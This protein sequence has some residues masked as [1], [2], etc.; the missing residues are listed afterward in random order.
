MK[1]VIANVDSRRVPGVESYTIIIQA[2]DEKLLAAGGIA[3]ERLKAFYGAGNSEH[4]VGIEALPQHV[5]DQLSALLIEAAMH[6]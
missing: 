3:A 2:F 5:R 1:V 6:R 4:G